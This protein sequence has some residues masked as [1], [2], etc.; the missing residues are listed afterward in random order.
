MF[1]VT[2]ILLIVVADGSHTRHRGVGIESSIV[3]GYSVPVPKGRMVSTARL[4]NHRPAAATAKPGVVHDYFDFIVTAAR[5]GRQHLSSARVVDT[6]V[7]GSISDGAKRV[8]AECHGE[9]P[10]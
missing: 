8:V 1:H 9:G 10:P 3:I 6:H 7:I 5:S 4:R 2:G